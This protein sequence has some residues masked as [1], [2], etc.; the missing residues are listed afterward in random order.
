MCS[1][2]LG[3]ASDYDLCNQTW[4]AM[5]IQNFCGVALMSKTLGEA[6]LSQ[7]WPSED[8]AVGKGMQSLWYTSE[9]M[10]N[11]LPSQPFYIYI[12]NAMNGTTHTDIAHH[13]IYALNFAKYAELNKRGRLDYTVYY[14]DFAH[15]TKADRGMQRLKVIRPP[16]DLTNTLAYPPAALAASKT[17]TITV[18]AAPGAAVAASPAA[19]G[20]APAPFPAPA[21]A[22]EEFEPD[23]AVFNYLSSHSWREKIVGKD[24]DPVS[25]DERVLYACLA[26]G[27]GPFNGIVKVEE[28]KTVPPLPKE[29][30]GTGG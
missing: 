27:M 9:N 18:A 4:N 8:R 12:A 7:R 16:G 29:R 14:T 24:V 11:H 1:S 22:P 26:A 3:K 15:M 10:Q 6:K 25:L 21:P 19:P 28:N 23:S 5:S 30:S 2:K 17:E 20:P 13:S